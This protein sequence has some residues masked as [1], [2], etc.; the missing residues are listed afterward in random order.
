MLWIIR[1]RLI[2]ATLFRVG[3]IYAWKFIG[4]ERCLAV[5]WVVE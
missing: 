1:L 2:I 3:T 5:G 4:G